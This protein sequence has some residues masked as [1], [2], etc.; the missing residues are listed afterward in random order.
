MPAP[1]NKV[2]MIEIPEVRRIICPNLIS[3]WRL[4]ARRGRVARRVVRDELMIDGLMKVKAA[5]VFLF[6]N[7]PFTYKMNN[8]ATYVVQ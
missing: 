1:P 7:D 4:P 8:T 5:T 6:L 3:M 2:K